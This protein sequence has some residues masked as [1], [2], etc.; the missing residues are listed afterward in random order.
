MSEVYDWS[1]EPEE[2]KLAKERERER[3]RKEADEKRRMYRD[4]DDLDWLMGTGRFA[5]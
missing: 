3:V 5:Q 4:L 2:V 1:T